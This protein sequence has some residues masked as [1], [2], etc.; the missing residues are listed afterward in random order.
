MFV[1]EGERLKK[2]GWGGVGFGL[3]VL[4]SSYI[5]NSKGASV[6]HKGRQ[7]GRQA[8]LERGS[9]QREGREERKAGRRM[10]RWEG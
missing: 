4:K 6:M 3:Q 1:N 2:V 9:V 5:V 7:A 10:R 8:G